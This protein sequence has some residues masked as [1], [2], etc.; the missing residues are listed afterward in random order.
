V[1]GGIKIVGPQLHHS[2]FAT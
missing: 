2:Q 1:S